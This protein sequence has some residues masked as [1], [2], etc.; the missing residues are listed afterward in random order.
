MRAQQSR[1]QRQIQFDGK[2]TE[3][4]NQT[5]TV[6]GAGPLSQPGNGVDLYGDESQ[7]SPDIIDEADGMGAVTFSAEE[8]C[9][10]FGK[11]FHFTIIFRLTNST[12]GPSS[13]ISLTRHIS[14]AVARF[15]HVAESTF[16][17]ENFEDSGFQLSGGVVSMSQPSSPSAR[18]M[19]RQ[20]KKGLDSGH[21]N[22]HAL[23]SEKKA[24]QLLAQYFSD[25]GL[26]FPYLHKETFMKTY[27][28]MQKKNIMR[29]RRT[30]L[31]LLNI[32]M[33]LATSVAVESGMNAEQR[34][35]ESETYY[36]RAVGLCK[37]Q[38]MRGTSLEVGRSFHIP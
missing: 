20:S 8:Y 16:A 2:G 5:D 1:S 10:F 26:L 37:E 31:G 23:P 22:I 34:S 11:D 21:I 24:R 4:S 19:T 38:I 29:V 6:P 28:E 17:P 14:R 3:L 32:V 12:K 33:A 15:S 18:D 30:W 35:F 25:T 13:N 27:D 36:Q 9:G 7:D